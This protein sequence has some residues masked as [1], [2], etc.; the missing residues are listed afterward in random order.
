MDYGGN[1]IKL[2]PLNADI[3]A[4]KKDYALGIKCAS[5]IKSQQNKTRGCNKERE[6]EICVGKVSSICSDVNLAVAYHNGKLGIYG[7]ISSGKLL[8]FGPTSNAPTVM[9]VRLGSVRLG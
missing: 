5:Q 4:I 9:W 8:R 2:M 6:W 1:A 7:D 3:C